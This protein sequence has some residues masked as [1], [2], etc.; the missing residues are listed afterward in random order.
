[1][2]LQVSKG[3]VNN[4]ANNYNVV[5]CV[6]VFTL[7]ICAFNAFDYIKLKRD[8]T[9]ELKKNDFLLSKSNYHS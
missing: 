5:I 8:I 7:S 2:D 6:V 1:M 3:F 9:I 4:D